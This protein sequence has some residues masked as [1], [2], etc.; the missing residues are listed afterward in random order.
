MA[1]ERARVLIAGGGIAGLE[2]MLALHELAEDRVEITLVAAEP[3]FT[4]RPMIIEEPF[5]LAPAERRDLGLMTRDLGVRFERGTLAGVDPEAHVAS[6]EGG[7]SVTFD[8]AVVCVGGRSRAAYPSATT[9]RSWSEPIAIDE[10]LDTAAAHPTRRIAF[11]VPP[12]VAWALPLYELAMLSQRLAGDRH[13]EL[14]MMIVSTE[15]APLA[16]FGSGPSEAV[17]ELLGARGIA[18]VGDTAVEEREGEFVMRPGERPLEAGAVVALP[19]ISGPGITGLPADADGFIRIDQNARVVGCP[20][21]FAAGDG[22]NFPIKQGGIGT[23]QADAAAEMIAARA[24]AEVDPQPFRP[25]LRGKL[26]TGSESLSLRSEV[27]GGAGEGVASP[28]YLWWPPH[29]VGGRFL[30]PYLADASS[31]SDLE[32]PGGTLDVEVALPV[33][34]HREPMGLD[35]L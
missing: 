25:V 29:K 16:L 21:V 32:P 18:F 34:W 12:G 2:T 33:E 14:E 9:L 27:S 6:L 5:S 8:V 22:T 10:A 24:G 35:P 26:I 3:E 4:Y 31:L 30:A 20:D 19:L 13:L 15:T 7:E 23:Q 1:S 11:V 17:G 28:D